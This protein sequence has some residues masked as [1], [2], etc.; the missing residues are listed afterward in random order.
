M[1]KKFYKMHGTGNDYIFFNCMGRGISRPQA[2]ARRL[3]DRHFSVGGDGVILIEKSKIADA[4]MRIFNADGSEGK[5]CGNGIRCVA[6][7]LY[8][9]GFVRRREMTV[10]TRSGVRRLTVYTG[11]DGC[12]CRVCADMGRAEFAPAAIPVRLEGDCIVDRPACI[13]GR[14]Y[15]ITC[16]SMGNPHCVVFGPP[17]EPFER[18]GR[19]FEESL[20]FPE[21]INAEFACAA[22][23]DGLAV[24]VWERGSGETLSCGTGACAAVAAAVRNGLCRA[25]TEVAVR[26]KG[27][28]LSVRY[29][30]ERVFMTGDAV[31]AY[32]GTVEI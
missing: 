9:G 4:K 2:L 7:F 16:V 6:K 10:E 23:E 28:V 21:G 30:P 5:M 12:V 19:A 24:R 25:G 1:R 13:G 8:D 14:E 17:P 3:S 11:G 18:T 32:V 31:L 29:T 20:L 22:G 27:G 26:L 15:R